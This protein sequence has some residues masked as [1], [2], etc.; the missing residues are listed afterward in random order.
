MPKGEQTRQRIVE[1]A[2]P[3]FNTLGYSGASLAALIDATGLEK[4]GIYN[5]FASKEALALAAFDYAVQEIGRRYLEAVRARRT[6]AGKLVALVEVFAEQLDAPWLPGGC[7]VGNTAIESDDTSP[8][9]RERARAAM[10][11]WHRLIGS[12]VKQGVRSGE[13]VAYADPYAVATIVTATLEGALM[14]S[15]LYDDRVYM[16]RA[17]A[18]LT[19]YIRTLQATTGVG[20]A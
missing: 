1:R 15:R 5:H 18:H 17:V 2:A 8:T 16:E 3:I 12:T 6:A 4:G 20:L 9:L 7:P 14:L 19:A 13:L 11:S 10:T